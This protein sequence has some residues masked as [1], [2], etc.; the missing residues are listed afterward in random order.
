MRASSSRSVWTSL[1]CFSGLL[2]SGCV[3]PD[4][5]TSLEQATDLVD[6]GDELSGP[7]G[8]NEGD[9]GWDGDQLSGPDMEVMADLGSVPDDPTEPPVDDGWDSTEPDVPDGTVMVTEFTC[10]FTSGGFEA[11]WEKIEGDWELVGASPGG[12]PVEA[13]LPCQEPPAD[14]PGPYIE[15]GDGPDIFLHTPGIDHLLHPTEQENYW[16]GQVWPTHP[17][18]ACLAGIASLGLEFPIALTMR[19][20]ELDLP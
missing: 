5:V 9:S 3:V 15:W 1:L 7:S 14:D 18:E 2:A 19:L 10:G 8:D 12:E 20:V 13:L 16:V 11:E 4:D 6:E 17:N